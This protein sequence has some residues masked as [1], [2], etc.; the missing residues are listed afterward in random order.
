MSLKPGDVFWDKNDSF[1]NEPAHPHIV[2]CI[3]DKKEIVYVVTSTNKKTTKKW[4]LQR[5][6]VAE[7]DS[8]TYIVAELA[9]CQDLKQDSHI[10]CNGSWKKSEYV[11]TRRPLYQPP[12]GDFPAL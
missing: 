6:G 8:K 2:I 12:A 10:D 9:N 4:A 7:A 3:S 11:L 5:E 1:P